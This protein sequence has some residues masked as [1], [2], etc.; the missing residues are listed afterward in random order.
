M[1]S[2]LPSHAWSLTA[3]GSNL[4]LWS[5]SHGALTTKPHGKALSSPTLYGSHSQQEED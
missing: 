2:D 5:P 3:Q 4:G 1:V